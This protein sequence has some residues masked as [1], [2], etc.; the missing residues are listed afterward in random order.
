MKDS[1]ELIQRAKKALKIQSDNEL[2][3]R[4]NYSRT[5]FS[6]AK[7]GHRDIPKSLEIK[8]RFAAGEDPADLIINTL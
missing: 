4:I 2:C 6:A 7:N 5:N 3:R 8:L 1:K